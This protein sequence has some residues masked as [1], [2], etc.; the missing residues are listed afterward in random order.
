MK[1]LEEKKLKLRE[2]LTLVSVEDSGALLDVEKRC[3]H[4]LNA[5]AFFIASLLENGYRYDEIQIAV[6]SEFSIDMETAQ[7]DVDSFIE[8]L[9]RHGLLSIGEE[10][11]EFNK[12]FDIK[13]GKKTLSSSCV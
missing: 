7:T 5:T 1:D 13:Q 9:Q 11:I 2:D 12:A 10:N 8:E 4:D 6:V 3:Y